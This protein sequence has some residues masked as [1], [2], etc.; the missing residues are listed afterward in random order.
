MVQLKSK[1]WLRKINDSENSL[2][3]TKTK[4]SSFL[5]TFWPTRLRSTKRL[6]I[7]SVILEDLSKEKNFKE[8]FKKSFKIL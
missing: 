1:N 6:L 5:S 4:S 2:S 7:Y 8:L 3:K